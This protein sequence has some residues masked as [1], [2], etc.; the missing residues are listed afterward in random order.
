MNFSQ[1]LLSLLIPNGVFYLP[2]V[3]I[4]LLESLYEGWVNVEVQLFEC[5]S[6]SL[7]LFFNIFQSSALK[8]L[9]LDLEGCALVNKLS[10]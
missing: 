9:G 5:G 4:D 8:L 1:A 2:E 7:Q 10:Q 3:L 6:Q